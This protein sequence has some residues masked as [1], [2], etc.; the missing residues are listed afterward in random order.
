MF[1]GCDAWN[2][3]KYLWRVVVLREGD[4]DWQRLSSMLRRTLLQKVTCMQSGVL[5]VFPCLW[6]SIQ[7]SC[8]R[9][10]PRKAIAQKHLHLMGSGA[11]PSI[12]I[13]RHVQN[14]EPRFATGFAALN[15]SENAAAAQNSAQ[16]QREGIASSFSAAS[17]SHRTRQLQ[18]IY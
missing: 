14:S 13:M 18:G 15:V 11:V 7:Y 16:V 1:Q 12:M 2:S 8:S 10:E 6:H 4:V 3:K 9:D 5:M 17:L